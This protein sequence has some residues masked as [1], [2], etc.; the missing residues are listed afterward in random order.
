ML[1][2]MC[3]FMAM[4][5][6]RSDSLP[7]LSDLG[8]GWLRPL[9]ELVWPSTSYYTSI[10]DVWAAC[11][12]LGFLFVLLPVACQKPWATKIAFHWC[13]AALYAMRT[14]S[15][16]ATV[17]P[18]TSLPNPPN[19]P[20][21]D[22]P[23]IPLAAVLVILGVRSTLTDYMFSGHTCVWVL[24]AIFLWQYRKPGAEYTALA[25]LFWAFNA[26][27]IVLLIGVRT[28]YSADVV[29]AVFLTILVATLYYVLA[30]PTRRDC[31]AHALVA[32]CED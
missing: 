8:F 18:Q 16:L 27:G 3:W 13:L 15:L 23:S 4:A 14:I 12:Y 22:V 30:H 29:I 6:L 26:T 5:Q 20:Y 32:W 24:T 25:M 10:A 19:A 7:A 21:A 1:L 11:S 28:H 2:L 9:R 17:Y 31:W